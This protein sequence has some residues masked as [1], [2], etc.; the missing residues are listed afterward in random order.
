MDDRQSALLW[1]LMQGIGA[2]APADDGHG[3]DS[4]SY[5]QPAPMEHTLLALRP[6]MQPRQQRMIDL[7]IK[8]Q[9]VAALMTE[10]Q[11]LP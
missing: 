11:T 6:L 5:A 3:F 10:L 8:M 4:A 2:P 1:Q 9:E 7:M